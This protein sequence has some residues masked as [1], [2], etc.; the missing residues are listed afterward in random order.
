MSASIWDKSG[1]SQIEQRRV[2]LVVWPLLS[3]PPAYAMARLS[4]KAR[5]AC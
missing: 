5:S 3:A 1:E 4:A 2:D